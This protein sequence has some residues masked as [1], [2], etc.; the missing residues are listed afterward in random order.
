MSYEGSGRG[1]FLPLLLIAFSFGA[2]FPAL[3]LQVLS[4]SSDLRGRLVKTM[5]HES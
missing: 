5:Y 1:L 4:V 2:A 3:P